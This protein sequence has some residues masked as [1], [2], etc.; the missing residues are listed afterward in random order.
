MV[1]DAPLDELTHRI[2]HLL[3]SG[4]ALTPPVVDFINT[5]FSFPSRRSFETILADDSHSERDALVLLLFSPDAP[6]QEAIEPVVERLGANAGHAPMLKRH[7]RNHPP[8][9]RF[10]GPD[11]A[12]WLEMLM[13]VEA[14]DGFVDQL[15]IGIRLSDDLRRV[16]EAYLPRPWINPVKVRLRNGRYSYGPRI[17]KA[18][19]E[20]IRRADPGAAY[21]LPALDFLIELPGLMADGQDVFGALAARKQACLRQLRAA[22]RQLAVLSR[23][24]VETVITTGGRITGIDPKAAAETMNLI[25]RICLVVYGTTSHIDPHAA[26]VEMGMYHSGT[27]IRRLIARWTAIDD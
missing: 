6:L 27:D 8:D 24:N 10:V 4:V 2:R 25:D 23:Y 22:D 14:V 17:L 11:A 19:C 7:F 12:V 26:S 15:R 18:M 9:V 3:K 5:T 16:V 21:F 20:F 1:L 13:P